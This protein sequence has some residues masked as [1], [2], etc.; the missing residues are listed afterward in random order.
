MEGVGDNHSNF[1]SRMRLGGKGIILF[2][3][4]SN[5]KLTF[6]NTHITRDNLSLLIL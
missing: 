1:K 2:A 5:I 4:L 6:V 3:F